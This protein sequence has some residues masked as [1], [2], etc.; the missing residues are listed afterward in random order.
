M[1]SK[2]LQHITMWVAAKHLINVRSQCPCLSAD[3]LGPPLRAPTAEVKVPLMAATLWEAQWGELRGEGQWL[4]SCTGLV[5]GLL[6]H[7]MLCAAAC[8]LCGASRPCPAL[9]PPGLQNSRLNRPL[10]LQ[11][12]QSLALR[13][14]KQEED[15]GRDS[16]PSD[17]GHVPSSTSL[18]LTAGP[19]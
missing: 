9:G 7:T 13:T 16:V 18:S 15:H 19:D 10:H 5:P 4:S 3:S 6:H 12:A 8:S 11:A 2:A 17:P 1:F 14:W